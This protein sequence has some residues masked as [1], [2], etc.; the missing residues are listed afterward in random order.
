MVISGVLS[1]SEIDIAEV[2]GSLA[3]TLTY[4]DI[5]LRDIGKVFPAGSSI[6]AQKIEFRLSALSLEGFVVNIFNASLRIRHLEPLFLYG[7]IINGVS[8]LTLYT[9]TLGLRALLD[10]LYPQHGLREISGRLNDIDIAVK[11]ALLSPFLEGD[12]FVETAT[13]NGFSLRECPL[14][15]D[16]RLGNLRAVP[17]VRGTLT[18]ARGVIKGTNGAEIRIH[19]GSRIIFSGSLRQPSFDLSGET[20]IGK[21]RITVGLKGSPSDPALTLSS[22]PSLPQERLLLMLATG[23]S[24]SSTGDALA[25][26]QL[27]PGVA[28]D[29]LDYFVL[30]G[31]GGRLADYL[32]VSDVRVTYEEGKKGISIQRYKGLGEMNPDQLWETTMNPEKRTLLQVR[33]EDAVE[34][35]EI[36]TILMGD[37]VEPRREFIQNNALE[38]STLDI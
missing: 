1:A 12:V 19:P 33:I 4:K 13:H 36:F 20:V 26:K 15:F 31:Q 30:G 25:K 3:Q 34:T 14:H 17:Q 11:G 27:S 37:E 32:G 22:E 35:D 38:V 5:V 6:A 24:W 18:S 2:S 21:T 23:K 10:I 29:F 16:L 9:K 8:D 7:S 28:A